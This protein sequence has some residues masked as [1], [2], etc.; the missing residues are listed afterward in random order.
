[1]QKKYLKTYNKLKKSG[2]SKEQ[3]KLINREI[4]IIKSFE[5]SKGKIPEKPSF[6]GLYSQNDLE[7]FQKIKPD[8]E[9]DFVRTSLRTLDELLDKDKKREA[10]GFPRRIRIGKLV[11]PGKGD[12]GKVVV[13]PSTTEPKFYH[14]DSI[15]EENETGGNGEGEEGEV[16]GEQQAQPQQGEGD[17]QGAGQGE[18]GDHDMS[19][20]AFDLG[21]VLTEK[22][23]LPNLKDKG[24][25]RS[26]SKYTYDLTDINRGFGQV[27]DKKAT[28]KKIIETN[29]QLGKID[30]IKQFSGEDLLASPQDY[31]YRILSREKDFETQAVV[32][33]LRDYSGS[34]QGK[35]TEVVTTQHLLIYS[36]LMFQYQNNVVTRFILHDTEAKEVPDFYTYYRSQIAGGTRVAPAFQL[37]NKIVEEERLAKDY[38]IYVFHGTDGDDWDT[39][40]KELLDA[41]DKMT[42]YANRIGI[43]VAKNS[44]SGENNTVVEINFEN[45]GILKEK[46][47]LVRIDGFSA[48]EGTEDRI[49]EGIKKLVG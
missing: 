9:K 39:D 27:L 38:N 44:W 49:I 13:V 23:E 15:T 17:A 20:E 29:I 16:I 24:K 7:V 1:M 32:F 40:G 30:G 33:F 12:K 25:K 22:F 2:L 11:K 47:Q 45:S 6:Q 35:P 42:L 28:L 48:E 3:E 26:F 18:G 46:P 19:Q 14:D 4:E 36:W 31:V 5:N 8:F 37:V 34:M 43:T 21:R 10:D 41:I